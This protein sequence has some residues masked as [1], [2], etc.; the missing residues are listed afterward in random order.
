MSITRRLFLRNTAVVGAVGPSALA[1]EVAAEAQLTADERID[2]AIAEIVIALREK[3]PDC[4][5]RI[6]DLDNI[7][8]GMV[9]I[10]THCGDDEPGHI[11]HRRV[12]L[13]RKAQ[14]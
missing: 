14:A 11:R 12:G 2:A 3:Y 4:P 8:Q 10:L 1:V 5:I 9:L 6:D 13:A 7:D